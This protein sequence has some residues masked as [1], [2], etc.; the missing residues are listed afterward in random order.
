[1]ATDVLATVPQ[2]MRFFRAQMR[3]GR[4]EELSV[5][6]FRALVYICN[7]PDAR[8]AA[9]AEHIGISPAAASR[10]VDHLVQRRLIDRRQDRSDRRAVALA[11]TA[12]GQAVFDEAYRDVH[13]LMAA[14]LAVLSPTERAQVS[15]AMELLGRLVSVG[16][17]QPPATPVL[18]PARKSPGRSTASRG[19]ARE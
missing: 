16:P 6:Q 2:V 9:V 18:R 19:S 14:R 1:M 11:L 5:P 8:L 13:G 10:L 3:R 4:G 12:R 7:Y 17:I 15:R